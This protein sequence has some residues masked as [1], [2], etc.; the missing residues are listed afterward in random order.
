M[1]EEE[2]G[3]EEGEEVVKE[4]N[5]LFSFFGRIG[6]FNDFFSFD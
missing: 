2:E 3:L 4:N 5:E 1:K 6:I